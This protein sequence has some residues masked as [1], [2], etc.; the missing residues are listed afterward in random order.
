MA[1]GWYWHVHHEIL[2]EWCYDYDERVGYIKAEKPPEE[3]EIRLRLM[4]P[5][6]DV[7]AKLTKARTEYD[8]ARVEYDRAGVECF[9]EIKVLHR[10]QCPNCPW[11]G[12]TIFPGK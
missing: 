8:K 10:A 4:Q 2:Y 3:V 7:P 5:V 9:S 1:S 11:D 12:N 6:R